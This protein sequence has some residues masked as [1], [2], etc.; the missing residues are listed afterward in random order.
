MHSSFKPENFE[1]SVDLIEDLPQGQHLEHAAIN[2]GCCRKTIYN[3]IHTVGTWL[4]PP[5]RDA[6]ARKSI[7][8]QKRVA[9][10]KNFLTPT[11][12]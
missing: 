7:I 5:R 1:A 11:G 3:H 10:C 12:R 9:F 6:N 4:N 2:L 8:Q